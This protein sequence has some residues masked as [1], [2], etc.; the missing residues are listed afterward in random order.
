MF[1]VVVTLIF[2][3]GGFRLG[4]WWQVRTPGEQEATG[5][6]LSLGP[7]AVD[8]ER[9]RSILESLGLEAVHGVTRR[10]THGGWISRLSLPRSVGSHYVPGSV[11]LVRR[12]DGA[13]A[14][15]ALRRLETDGIGPGRPDGWGWL[16]ACHP[17]HLDC[18]KEVAF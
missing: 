9:L 17:I 5:V 14:L 8:P 10:Q 13:S 3:E 7:L 12:P 18:T 2:Y 6:L 4:R 1:D 11:W 15:P 16:V